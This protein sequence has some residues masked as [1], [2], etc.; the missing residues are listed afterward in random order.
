MRKVLG[1]KSMKRKREKFALGSVAILVLAV[2]ITYLLCRWADQPFYDSWA[3]SLGETCVAFLLF[4]MQGAL[5]RKIY[6][7]VKESDLDLTPVK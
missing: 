4:M 6:I 3:S 7:L 5:I 1:L 2:V